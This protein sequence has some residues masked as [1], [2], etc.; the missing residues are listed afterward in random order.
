MDEPLSCTEIDDGALIGQLTETQCASISD[1]ISNTCGCEPFV[2]TACPDGFVLGNPLGMLAF[3]ILEAPISCEQIEEGGLADLVNQAQCSSI[4]DVL[5]NTCGCI[6]EGTQTMSPTETPIVDDGVFAEIAGR[7]AFELL[8]VA[9]RAAGLD[10]V[11]SGVGP[12]TLLAPTDKAIR[13]SFGGI[14]GF[15]Q[16]LNDIDRLRDIL[17]YHVIPGKIRK[18]D[19]EE[20][21]YTSALGPSLDFFF[22][23][24][25]FVFNDMAEIIGFNLPASN[26]IIHAID[27]VLIPPRDG[28]S[29]V[30]P[31]TAAPVTPETAAP[32]ATAPE[33]PTIFEWLSNQGAFSVLSSAIV[34]AELDG[35]LDSSDENSG[36]P[37]TIF[38]PTKRA[39]DRS[40]G[41]GGVE[42]ALADP[43]KLR[44]ILLYHV[45]AGLKITQADLVGGNI[46]TAQGDAVSITFDGDSV[47]LNDDATI[48]HFNIM[49]AN[50]I[51]HVI[52]RVL[53]P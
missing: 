40:L 5:F 48:K 11:L 26:G 4:D 9:I 32:I 13:A 39:F 46:R 29:P 7:R 28:P 52:D 30:S 8:T 49:T 36:A 45:I 53:L 18:V 22:F 14:A 42:A 25:D 23:G 31:V 12:F 20:R 38:A 47:L 1:I 33:L 50:G 6:E 16:A 51:I 10:R 21:L 24:N 37:F 3:D 41:P 35:I 27:R 43:E 19:F 34:V 17:L 2:C 44:E 15:E